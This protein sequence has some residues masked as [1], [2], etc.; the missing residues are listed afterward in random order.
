MRGG[1]NVEEERLSGGG[2]DA[3]LKHGGKGGLGWEVKKGWEISREQTKLSKTNNYVAIFDE[4][5]KMFIKSYLSIL[6]G[7]AATVPVRFSK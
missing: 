4:T 5:N 2:E 7:E 6:L 1:C 3:R